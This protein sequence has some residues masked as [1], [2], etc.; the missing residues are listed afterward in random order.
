MASEAKVLL[1]P[2]P[3]EKITCQLR[4]PNIGQTVAAGDGDASGM[5]HVA[6]AMQRVAE[7]FDDLA[8]LFEE[9]DEITYTEGTTFV[10]GYR[11]FEF[12]VPR[13]YRSYLLEA[14]FH[15]DEVD[16]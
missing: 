13:R 15:P 7:R 14:G 6:V 3:D 11:V 8:L 9:C 5:S 2:S 16:V 4:F 12:Q 1:F 10:D